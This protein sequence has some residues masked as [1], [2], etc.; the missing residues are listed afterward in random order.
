MNIS[1]VFVINENPN[2]GL[3]PDLPNAAKLTRPRREVSSDESVPSRS[4]REEGNRELAVRYAEA[5]ESH[6]DPYAAVISNI[7]SDSTFGQ[8]RSQ[9]RSA[10]EDKDFQEWLRKEGYD[11]SSLEI[12][13]QQ[14]TLS[15]RNPKGLTQFSLKDYSAWATFADPILTAAKAYAPD[16]ITHSALYADSVPLSQ[17]AQF[18]AEKIHS[19]STRNRQR[20]QAVKQDN[21]L[22]TAGAGVERSEERLEAQKA[23]LGN[24]R[25]LHTFRDALIRALVDVGDYLKQQS[26][27]HAYHH[28]NSP[29]PPP[30]DAGAGLQ[31][32]LRSQQIRLDPD[33]GFHLGSEPMAGKS[34]NLLQFMTGNGWEHPANEDELDNMGRELFR[35][36]E[37]RQ[38]LGD[39]GGGLSWPV[40]PDTQMQQDI[41]DAVSF[42]ALQLPEFEKLRLSQNAFGYL[43]QTVDWTQEELNNPRQ[44]IVKLLNSPVAKK[45]GE[46]LRDEFD[47][48]GS[49]DDWVLMALQ[50][51]LNRDAVLKPDEK[52]KVAGF[53]LSAREHWGKP[54]S[55]VVAGLNRHLSKSYGHNAPIAAYLLLSHHAPELLVKHLPDHVT[56]GSPAW[57]SL[58][59]IVAKA[60]MRTPGLA[61]TKAYEQLLKEDL[62][63]ITAAEK[64]VETQAGREGL[65]HW[66]VAD[67]AIEKRADNNYTA[68]EIE[69]AA[70]LAGERFDTLETASRAQRATV[71]SRKALALNLLKEH[72][73]KTLG[74]IDFERKFLEP[75]E[76]HNNLKGPYSILDIYLSP[77]SQTVWVS[78]DPAVDVGSISH[79]LRSLPPVNELFEKNVTEFADGFKGAL[80][81]SVKNMMSTLP[82]SD[83]EALEKGELKF[84]TQ[85]R[86]T[87]TT[88]SLGSSRIS[89]ASHSDTV[90]NKAVLIESMHQGKRRIYEVNTQR[91]TLHERADLTEG[92][93]VGL[94]EWQSSGSK[95]PMISIRSNIRVSEVKTEAAQ[96]ATRPDISSLVQ[97]FN[98]PRTQFIAD[99][100]ANQMFTRDERE[101]LIRN[102]RGVTTF[103]TEVTV[104]EQ[105]QAVTRALIPF[106][107]AIH[108][109]E[110]GKVGEGLVF[111]AFDVFGFVVGGAGAVSRISKVVKVGGSAGGK[112][113]RLAR[114]LLSA[115]N[116]FAGG[117]AIVTR[118]LPLHWSAL[119][120]GAFSWKV[121]STNRSVDRVYQSKP[122]D[123]V[124]GTDGS[125]GGVQVLAQQDP[126]TQN[127]Y[128]YDLKTHKRYGTPLEAFEV[129]SAAA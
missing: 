61:V 121:I 66:A 14:G 116:P 102:A 97:T 80:E 63:P 76:L 25:D 27:L 1:P 95:N 108:S 62:K 28:R 15:V 11:P 50:V 99:T 94:G 115:A 124:A 112:A 54:L 33:S 107:S 78:N 122:K 52:N 91:G 8:W 35:A 46:V 98:S 32:Y 57:V 110:Q 13:P 65:I 60:E 79:T 128:R 67:G 5:L 109:F 3:M 30:Y 86:F 105:I 101:T 88:R 41:Y 127:W 31:S 71:P 18:H 53:D 72:L 34:V 9:L 96:P 49:G 36:V 81:V 37:P 20:A 118:G 47:G 100:V 19:D 43:A 69:R 92:V 10:L 106:A 68:E 104:F 119:G 120:K 42:N 64:E 17:V 83:K 7:P 26:A 59:S 23:L 125:T 73:T 84:Y 74:N 39:L 111:L 70:V 77:Q 123:V 29:V 129:E 6:S 56:Y 12:F 85:E 38:H 117:K 24:K 55:S 21:A 87:R 4:A 113:G 93:K 114:G 16:G 51:G 22:T 82:V 90:D 75:S 40:P 2:S 89:S 48:A 103:D 58:K 44:A 45:L 126:L